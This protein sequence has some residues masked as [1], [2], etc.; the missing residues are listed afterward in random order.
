M[1]GE[2]NFWSLLKPDGV[3]TDIE[4]LPTLMTDD[5]SV[6]CQ[7]ALAEI[8]VARLPVNICGDAIRDGRLVKVLPHYRLQA[9]GLHAVFAS[10]RGLV[11]AVR[12]FLDLLAEE[13]PGMLAAVTGEYDDGYRPG[14]LSSNRTS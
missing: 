14:S 6:L 1:R 3:S 5:I 12:P 8:G 10:R 13:L 4:Y 9:P 7:A 2:R 11:P